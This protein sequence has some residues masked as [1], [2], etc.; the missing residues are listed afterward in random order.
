MSRPINPL[1]KQKLAFHRSQCQARYRHEAW[2]PDFTFE[3]WWQIWEHHWH[4]RGT[5]GHCLIMVRRDPDRAWS[6]RN[7]ELMNRREW[8]AQCGRCRTGET[9]K[10]GGTFRGYAPISR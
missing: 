9:P 10:R 7:V 1:M 3:A 8:L 4:N 5:F 6:A 2:D